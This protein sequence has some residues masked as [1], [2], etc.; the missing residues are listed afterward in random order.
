MTVLVYDEFFSQFHFYF[1]FS[2]QCYFYFLIFI[3]I[4][5]VF[6]FHLFN[7]SLWWSKSSCYIAKGAFNPFQ[8][9]DP[10]LCS[11][12]KGR[13]LSFFDVLKKYRS[14]TM[15]MKLFNLFL[16]HFFSFDLEFQQRFRKTKFLGM[17]YFCFG[18][19][20]KT[21]EPKFGQ[22][23]FFLKKT[24]IKHGFSVAI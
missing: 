22:H 9:N 10:F 15:R 5:S 16:C 4:Y 19:N 12:K 11:I 6:C 2:F 24:S 17:L 18:R 8:T 21:D 7:F 1:L 13:N 23:L 14:G 3:F 20:K